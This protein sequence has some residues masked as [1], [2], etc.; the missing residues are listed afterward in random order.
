MSTPTQQLEAA[1]KIIANLVRKLGGKVTISEDE[2]LDAYLNM[3]AD[4]KWELVHTVNN[5]G[6]F[7]LE[8]VYK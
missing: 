4:Y 1:N 8:V 7:T 3:T 5:D 6:G 2:I